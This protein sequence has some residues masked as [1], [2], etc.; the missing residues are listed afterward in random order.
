MNNSIG[1]DISKG[2]SM[3][4]VMRP[5]GEVVLPPFECAHTESEL[6]KLASLLK[7]SRVSPASSWSPQAIT[8]CPSPVSSTTPGSMF[9]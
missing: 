1:I 4:A 2:K 7:T 3:I 9:A 8:T 5:L 6:E